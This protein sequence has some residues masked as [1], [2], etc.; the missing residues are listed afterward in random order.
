MH[1]TDEYLDRIES[2][3]R[4]KIEAGETDAI[5]H[6]GAILDAAD[7]E[8]TAVANLGWHAESYARHGIAVFPVAPRGKRPLTT[9]GLKDG[10]TDTHTIRWWWQQH[11]HANIGAVCGATFDVIDVDGATGVKAWADM[12]E[13]GTLPPLIGQVSTPRDGGVHLYVAPRGRGNAAKFL[14]GMDYRG[15]GGYVLLPPSV[16]DEHGQGRTYRW[17]RPLEGLA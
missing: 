6:L 17:I 14:P 11:P 4:I 1:Y 16:T 7:A 12:V 10:T 15:E 13:A 9:H 5:D 3:L 8:R 2:L